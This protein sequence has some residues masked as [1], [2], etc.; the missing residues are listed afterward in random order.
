MNAQPAYIL[1]LAAAHDAPVG[2]K[3]K[4]LA[5]LIGLGLNVPPGFVIINASGEQLPA[6][7][8]AHY[9]KIGGGLVAVR[10]SALGEDSAE[11]SFAG[12]YETILNVQGEA[13]LK[14]A[15]NDCLASLDNQ[16]SQAYQQQAGVSGAQMSVV[17][18]KMA[19]AAM[20]G[21][22]FTV[23][24][25]SGDRGRLVLDAARG[26]GEAVVS[27]EVT[28]DHYEVDYQG[29]VLAQD[30]TAEQP[31]L[32]QATIAE[33]TRV[34]LAAAQKLGQPLDMEWAVDEQGVIY[35]L[36]ARPITTLGGTL[37]ELDTP[38]DNEKHVYTLCNVSEG[39][40]GAQKPLTLSVTNQALEVAMQRI[41]M[42]FGLYE[43]EDLSRW[44]V[45]MARGGHLFMNMNNLALSTVQILGGTS[46]A[47]ALAICGRTIAEIV[48]D[49]TPLTSAER[50]RC[51]GRY[52][53]SLFG[54]KHY[55]ARIDAALARLK[56][57]KQPTA[58]AQWRM[59][60]QQLDILYE[61]HHCHLGSSMFAGAMAPTLLGIVSKGGEQTDEHH[62]IVADWLGGADNV[63]S[64][65]IA[66]GA[67]KLQR[68][69]AAQP[70]AKAQFVDVSPEQ[71]LAYLH[72]TASGP[73]QAAFS[74]YMQRH[75]HR[76][77]LEMSMHVHEW[78]HDPLPL[79]ISMQ[80]GVA[81]ILAG[82]GEQTKQASS[83][84]PLLMRPIIKMAHNGVRGRE[85]SKSKMV[86][87]TSCFKQAYRDL[88]ALLVAESKLDHPEQ[89]YFLQHA[90]LGELAASDEPQVW[91]NLALAREKVYPSQ[92]R[93]HFD[94]VCVGRP[95]P[96][97]IDAGLV[98]GL[99][100][101][102][103]R[104]VSR[105]KVTG[106]A[107]VARTLAEAEGVQA[108][109]ILIAPITDV[110]WTPYF[111]IIGGLA[112]D[113][114]SAV[115]HGA[116]VAREFGLPCIVKTEIGTQV[117]NDGDIVTLDA[118]AGRLY[119]VE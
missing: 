81:G 14:Q 39:L 23:D 105:G 85:Y 4:G 63:E 78:A 1:E 115:S 96:K 109:D 8:L 95:R 22:L 5:E 68:L 50:L 46:D 69:I 24:P 31:L 54:G 117:F 62:A 35:W 56:L 90:E 99:K 75:G 38:I 30:L 80:A 92:Q 52:L 29:R 66:E 58:L 45:M 49:E 118:D 42:D 110:A 33:L 72:S 87:I 20:A 107:K 97:I 40:P 37:Y 102:E 16:R 77:L 7:L 3:A 12:Q 86:K 83:Q 100:V 119:L 43:K 32:S 26:L 65:D 71:A 28:P 91:Q 114:G 27:G 9:E 94:D 111:N 74:A 88:A 6:D 34:S 47:V 13:A 36:Q 112:T 15:I 106:R 41:L 53:K 59:I 44:T 2:G 25:V 64:A 108:G 89:I 57:P 11:A 17:V 82:R 61:A 18:Q 98:D 113:I 10:S 103:G 48:V 21:V 19:P 73:A 104:T 116:V 55:R 93:L 70:N 84:P 79:I 60:D 101:V 67:A 51:L 76:G